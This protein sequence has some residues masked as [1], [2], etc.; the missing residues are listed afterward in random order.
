MSNSGVTVAKDCI[1]KYQQLL[2]KKQYKYL[3]FQISSDFKEI[4]FDRESTSDSWDEFREA[5][6][7]S[8]T[9][10]KNGK[11]G[12]GPRYAIYDFKYELPSGEGNRSRV[13]FIFWCPDTASV[14]PKMIYA[15]SKEAL[16]NALSGIAAE[17]QAN[18]PDDIE[19]EEVLKVASK[20]KA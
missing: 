3:I 20:G 10:A 17:I 2:L 15:S 9:V 16:K 7:S 13:L 8:K 12:V 11:E 19:Y 5:L 14:Q 6:E 4:I 18:S 1:E